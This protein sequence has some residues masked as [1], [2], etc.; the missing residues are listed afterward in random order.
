MYYEE[1]V[2]AWVDPSS[3]AASVTVHPLQDVI[4]PALNNPVSYRASKPSPRFEQ[5]GTPVVSQEHV[6]G[7]TC[8]IHPHGSKKEMSL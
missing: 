7:D 3:C 6:V 1:R 2:E 4:P 8:Q 5:S